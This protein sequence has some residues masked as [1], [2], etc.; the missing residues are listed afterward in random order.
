MCLF[1]EVLRKTGCVAV[2]MECLLV[3]VVTHREAS[4]GL[5]DICLLQSG[6]VNLY[7]P[8]S[9]NLLGVG[10]L[11][12]SRFP[13][14]WFVRNAIFRSVCLNTFVMCDVSVPM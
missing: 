9:E 5:S 7:T 14:V 2:V 1:M 12:L 10:F 11:C 6:Q 4:S 3:L 13:I 8:D